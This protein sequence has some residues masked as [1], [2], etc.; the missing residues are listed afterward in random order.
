G[1]TTKLSPVSAP[2]RRR[3]SSSST[4]GSRRS[5]CVSAGAAV[6]G[7]C[8]GDAGWAGGWAG[9]AGGRGSGGCAKAAIPNQSSP[10]IT[11]A[12]SAVVVILIEVLLASIKA[13]QL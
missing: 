7:G 12:V 10:P 13:T 11:I 8:A 3:R 5:D 6:C 9:G 1:S 4:L 2:T